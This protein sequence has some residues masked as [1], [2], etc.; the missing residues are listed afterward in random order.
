MSTIDRPGV[1][2]IGGPNGAGKS[3]IAPHVLPAAP[4]VTEFVNADVIARGLSAFDPESV[5]VRAG[6]IMLERLCELARQ[7]VSFAF[8]ATLASRSLA[9]W[10]RHLAASGYEFH[11]VD[12]WL[13]T[14]ELALRRVADRVRAGGHHVAGSVVRRRYDAGLRNFFEVY[15]PLATTWRVYDNSRRELRLVAS[16]E[17]GEVVGVAGPATWDRISR[18]M[19]EGTAIDEAAREAVRQAIRAHQREGRPIVVE[20]NG[21]TMWI[22]AD[23]A[24]GERAPDAPNARRP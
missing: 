22:P 19:L 8:E 14:P 21:V 23:E 2:A 16:G 12:V 1:V 24:L 18:I 10:I 17:R 6:R 9:R 20:E 11:C 7:R 15:R 5:A 3:P 13:A 4:G